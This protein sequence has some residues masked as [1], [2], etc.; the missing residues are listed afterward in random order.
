MKNDHADD[1]K[2]MSAKSVMARYDDR[3]DMT[4]YRW[5]RDPAMQFPQPVYFGRLRF[6]RIDELEAWERAQAAKSRA[7]TH[8][9]EAA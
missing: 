3:S 2:Y 4:I 5:C 6:W 7:F 8:D 9:P 1:N